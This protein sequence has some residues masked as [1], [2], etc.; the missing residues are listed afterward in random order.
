M[1]TVTGENLWLYLVARAEFTFW[2]FT[3]NPYSAPRGD[4]LLRYRHAG[5]RTVLWDGI[6]GP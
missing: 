1:L 2:R 6:G 5:R 3:Q 4:H